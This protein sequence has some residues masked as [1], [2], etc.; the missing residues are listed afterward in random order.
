MTA[1]VTTVRRRW[2]PWALPPLLVAFVSWKPAS[3]GPTI[4]PFAVATGHACPLCGGTRA[5]S[6]L[7]RGD[8]DLAWQMH[9]LIFAILPLM[10]FGWIS[11]IGVTRGW[12]NPPPSRTT[13]IVAAV[14]G[15][16]FFG[17]WGLRALSGTLPP[18]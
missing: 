7:L 5:A 17:L 14:L 1:F 3:T 18:V 13:N 15:V 4:C 12:W 10:A 9:P 6:A 8:V 11:W 2:A 16:A